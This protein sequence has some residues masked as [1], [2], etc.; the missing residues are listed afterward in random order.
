M[1]SIE[2][3]PNSLTAVAI[4]ITIVDDG[5]FEG[6]EI[7]T[8]AITAGANCTV[9]SSLNSHSITSPDKGTAPLLTFETASSSKNEG[10][11]SDAAY[12]GVIR[13]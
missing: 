10:S 1:S 4:P 3:P 9:N 8:V 5:L 11:G 7:M 13:C 6:A 2:L 12:N